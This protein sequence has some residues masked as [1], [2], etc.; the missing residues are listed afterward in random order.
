M[1]GDV[2]EEEEEEEESKRRRND[3]VSSISSWLDWGS[4]LLQ[5]NMK[6]VGV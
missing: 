1:T 5:I 3:D 2:L 6:E 4:M